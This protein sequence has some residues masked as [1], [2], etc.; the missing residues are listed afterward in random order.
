VREVAVKT[1]L[2]KS[3]P[4]IAT[5]LAYLDDPHPGV[6]NA[7]LDHLSRNKNP[8]A[9]AALRDYI[10][11]DPEIDQDEDRL[12]ACYQ[13]L[14][15]CGGRESVAFLKKILLNRSAGNLLHLGGSAHQLGA[16]LA[17]KHCPGD[18]AEQVLRKAAKSLFPAIRNAARRAMAAKE[19]VHP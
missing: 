14:G 1:L 19:T 16:A 2:A 5:T 8:Q 12:L 4:S 10:Q 17:L 18:R 6:R 3:S 9:E 11:S 13:A 7:A 15:R